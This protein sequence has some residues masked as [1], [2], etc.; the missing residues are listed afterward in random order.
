VES[1]YDL[2][3][4]TKLRSL[5]KKKNMEENGNKLKKIEKKKKEKH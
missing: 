5:F 3:K 2:L 4:S 1:P